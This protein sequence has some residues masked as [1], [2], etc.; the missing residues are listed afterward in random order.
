M[1]L[2]KQIICLFL[3]NKIKIYLI[4]VSYYIKVIFKEFNYNDKIKN[5]NVKINKVAC[6]N[7]L[8]D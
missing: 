1:I 2:L 4:R 3:K 7:Y 8:D 6:L 5:V